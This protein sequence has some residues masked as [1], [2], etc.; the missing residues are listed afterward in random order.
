MHLSEPHRRGADAPHS[1]AAGGAACGDLI[2][3]AV[4]VEGDRV[5][6]AG[7]DAA[8]CAA[9]RAAGSAAVALVEGRP[10]L[11]AALV[12]PDDVAAE[13]GGLLPSAR[14]GAELAADALHRALGQAARDG[15]PRLAPSSRRTL[16]A[17]SGGVD[18][19]AAAQIA[20]DAGEE[21]V[22]VTLEL[23]ADPATDGERSCCSPQAVTG[24]RALAH[25]MGIP[26]FTLDLRESFRAQVV[27][28]FIAGYAAGSTPNPC[29]RCNGLVR[30]DAMLALAGKLGAARL[31]TGHYARIARDE[32]GP[33]V[34]A[35][36]DPAKDQSYMLARLDPAQL[37]RLSFPL[38]G[39]TKDAVRSLARDAGLPVADKRESQ[40]LCFVAG[41]GGRAFLRR[42]AGPR[43][44][45]GGEIVDRRGRVL[46]R[47]AGQHEFT[48]GQRRGIGIAAAEPLYVLAKDAR[49]GRVTVGTRGE[50]ATTSVRLVQAHLH[51]PAGAIDAVK[52]R[53]RSAPISAVVAGSPPSG[54][55]D[56][57]A[58]ELE[59]PVAAA[60]PGQVACLLSGDRVAGYGTIAETEVQ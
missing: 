48:V 28:D 30:F 38:G 12:T 6:E 34:R 45:R 43:L 18:S 13:L 46:G 16:V 1:G 25:R 57:L 33:L 17:M 2:R 40:D 11:E 36:A 55:H 24:A 52:L 31:A 19:A 51:R 53:Y 41:L 7:F 49:S 58:L 32:D 10:L 60:A 26:H 14:H 56:R 21:V 15:A 4:R 20:L 47:H 5:A 50:L 22:A 23:W 8:G 27:D 35:A 39:L 29:V 37:E 54:G 44:S 3:V 42:H 59:R 9:V